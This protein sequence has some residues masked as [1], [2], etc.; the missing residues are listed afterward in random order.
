MRGCRLPLV[1]GKCAKD[2]RM[3]STLVPLLIPLLIFIRFKR[4]GDEKHRQCDVSTK[5][6]QEFQF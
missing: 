6:L 2:R 5:R 3:L 4:V 1:V